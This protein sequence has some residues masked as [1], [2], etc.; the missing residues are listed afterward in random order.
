MQPAAGERRSMADEPDFF[1]DTEE[2]LRHFPIL[3]DLTDPFV[4]A[5]LAVLML[6]TIVGVALAR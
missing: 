2:R 1:H 5:A 6:L 3:R 4:A